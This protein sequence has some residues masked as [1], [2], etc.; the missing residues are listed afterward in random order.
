MTS[1]R[2][3]SSDCVSSRTSSTT[4]SLHVF[5]TIEERA[6]LGKLSRHFYYLNEPTVREQVLFLGAFGTRENSST[7]TTTVTVV[8][9]YRVTL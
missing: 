2:I 3:G 1:E 4:G 7:Y 8:V 9:Y 5:Q 6:S